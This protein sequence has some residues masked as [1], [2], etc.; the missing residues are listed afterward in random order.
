MM[1][2]YGFSLSR[3]KKTPVQEISQPSL[4][5]KRYLLD[6]TNVMFSAD[7]RLPGS[8]PFEQHDEAAA[9]ASVGR[10]VAKMRRAWDDEENEGGRMG[11]QWGFFDLSHLVGINIWLNMNQTI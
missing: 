8:S 10:D 6:Q 5:T 11:I 9:G 4:V 7:H 2:S 1:F 3:R